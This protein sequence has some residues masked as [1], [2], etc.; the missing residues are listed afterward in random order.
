MGQD[1]HWHGYS[2]CSQLRVSKGA[3]YTTGAGWDGMNGAECAH[4]REAVKVCSQQAEAES[5]AEGVMGGF[6]D[7]RLLLTPSIVSCVL[8]CFSSATGCFPVASAKATHV[9]RRAARVACGSARDLQRADLG[10]H[11]VFIEPFA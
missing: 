6:I 11:N 10:V 1:T 3:F 5:E 2:E 4:L 8:T 9:V 7:E